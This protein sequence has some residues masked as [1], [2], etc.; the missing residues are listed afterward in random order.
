[1][2][3]RSKNDHV[4][5]DSLRVYIKFGALSTVGKCAGVLSRICDAVLCG[6]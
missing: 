1:M 4:E 3:F 5:V 2:E 6:R